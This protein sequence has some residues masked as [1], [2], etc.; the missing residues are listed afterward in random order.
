VPHE[1]RAEV[2]LGRDWALE[3]ELE[4]GASQLARRDGYRGM[5]ALY[6]PIAAPDGRVRAYTLELHSGSRNATTPGN[7]MD[8]LRSYF[9]DEAG[10]VHATGEPRAATAADPLVAEGELKLDV[11]VLELAPKERHRWLTGP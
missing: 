7:D 2:P 1:W 8:K 4:D 9:V 10:M 6:R 3:R 11:T 5:R